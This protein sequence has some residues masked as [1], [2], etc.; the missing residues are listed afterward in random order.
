MGLFQRKKKVTPVEPAAVVPEPDPREPEVPPEPQPEPEPVPEPTPTPVLADIDRLIRQGAATRDETIARLIQEAGLGGPDDR[1]EVHLDDGWFAWTGSKGTMRS[2]IQVVGTRDTENDTW[3]WGWDHPSVKPELAQAADKMR[4]FGEERHS[5]TLTIR[6]GPCTDDQAWL[7]AH[8][9]VGLGLGDYV[10]RATS[11]T[12]QV[13][14][15]L[16]DITVDPT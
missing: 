6:Q 9:A 8:L 12:T 3:L 15:L 4:Q 13:F 11:G 7:F 1:W 14:L 16:T 2:P 5:T 10:Y